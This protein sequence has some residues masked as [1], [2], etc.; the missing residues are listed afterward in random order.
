MDAKIVSGFIFAKQ[1]VDNFDK[2]KMFMKKL[3]IKTV[4]VKEYVKKRR[5]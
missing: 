2:F 1:F 4:A 3:N 5:N